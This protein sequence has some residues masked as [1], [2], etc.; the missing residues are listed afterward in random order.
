MKRIHLEN[1]TMPS[2]GR[3]A[4]LLCLFLLCFGG[5]GCGS[6]S[7][8]VEIAEEAF[9]TVNLGMM[10]TEVEGM[11]GEGEELTQ[12]EWESIFGELE[13]T[14]RDG[15]Q[16]KGYRWKSPTEN[17]AIVV[18]VVDGEVVARGEQGVNL[19]HSKYLDAVEKK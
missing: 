6:S 11:L 7:G 19:D 18:S 10:Q 8:P 16:P 14:A 3:F 15:V 9:A 17:Y 12:A 2:E 13:G 1:A 4:W 5:V